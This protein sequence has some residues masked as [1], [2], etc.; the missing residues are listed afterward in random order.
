MA[1]KIMTAVGLMSGTSMDGI[2]AALIRSDG[3]G[4]VEPLGSTFLAYPTNLRRSIEAMLH[5]VAGCRSRDDLPD[6]ALRLGEDITAHHVRAV[7]QLL[8]VT[9]QAAAGVDVIGFHGQTVLHRP[10]IGLTVQLGDG[11]RLANVTGIATVWDMR[12]NDLAHGGQGAPLVPVYHQA[13]AARLDEKTRNCGVAFVNIGGISNATFLRSDAQP[14]A[15]DCGPGNALIDQWVQRQAGIPFDDGGR[16]AS[17]GV[18]DEDAVSRYMTLPFFCR[19]QPKSLDRQDFTLEPLGACELSDGAAT[20]AMV[21]ARAIIYEANAC[22]SP[23]RT[24]ILSGGGAHNSAIVSA[25]KKTA[26]GGMRIITAHDAGFDGDMMEAECWAYLAVRSLK[27]LPLT[28]PST[29]GCTMP[30]TGGMLSKPDP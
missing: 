9:G 2:D 13:L 15:T 8:A 14:A 24:I 21:T 30:V 7:E 5:T 6:E 19:A 28:Y 3:E 26:R 29:T 12:A 27:E 11:Q 1:T 23:P 22:Q 20:L 10:D 4:V 25:L 18:V 17:E 16:I